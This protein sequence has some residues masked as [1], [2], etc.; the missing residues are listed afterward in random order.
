MITKEDRSASNEINDRN[1]DIIDSAYIEDSFRQAGQNIK[2]LYKEETGSTNEDARAALKDASVLVIADRQNAGRGRRGRD[3]YSPKG[4]GLYMS[5]ALPYD[6]ALFETV[7]LTAIAAVAVAQSID[8]EVFE[9]RD[10]ALIKWVNDIYLKDRKVCGILCEAFLPAEDD[11][12]CVVAG[13]GINVYAPSGDFPEEIRDRAGYLVDNALPGLR[14]RLAAAVIKR[15][16]HYINEPDSALAVYRAKSNLMGCIVWINSFV[17]AASPGLNGDST[18][19]AVSAYGA[20]QT[21]DP[22]TAINADTA[23]TAD[24]Y[25]ENTAT[26]KGI[27]DEYRLLVEYADGHTE[28]LSSGEV[29]VV[30]I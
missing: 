30:S 18:H 6:Q 26:V 13:I 4:S 19:G 12:G 9:G 17:P 24:S 3:F 14:T 23:Q 29:S 16:F 27:D 20:G 21:F 2:V 15:L 5:L 10:T 11:K 8:E 28:A 25:N 22:D 7:K 1:V